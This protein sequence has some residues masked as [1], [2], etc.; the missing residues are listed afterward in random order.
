[1]ATACVGNSACG[2]Q[3][4]DSSRARRPNADPAMA[5]Q[6]EMCEM[7]LEAGPTTACSFFK[8]LTLSFHTTPVRN[9]ASTFEKAE[10]WYV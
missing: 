7:T 5:S 6:I 3:N 4:V 8:P 2:I 1:M 9:E 10:E